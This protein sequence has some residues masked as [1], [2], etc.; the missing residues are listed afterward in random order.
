MV[1][2]GCWFGDLIQGMSGWKTYL[3][4]TGWKSHTENIALRISSGEY[5]PGMSAR[6]KMEDIYG[7]YI[8][9][10]MHQLESLIPVS[11]ALP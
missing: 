3:G 6:T 2:P 11:A 10:E 7:G 9:I 5:S 1:I 4:M 8:W